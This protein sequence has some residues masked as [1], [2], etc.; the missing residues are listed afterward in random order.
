LVILTNVKHHN[1]GMKRM[2]SA[3]VEAETG[4]GRRTGAHGS[5]VFGAVAALAAVA[6][7]VFMGVAVHELGY[8]SDHPHAFGPAHVI[9]WGAGGG[10]VLALAVML[11]AWALMKRDTP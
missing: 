1:Q 5:A 10:V 8:A 11:L 6:A 2:S 3:T 7:V 4:R 9:A